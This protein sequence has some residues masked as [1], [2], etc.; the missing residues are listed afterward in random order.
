[1][2][3]AK[4]GHFWLQEAKMV[5]TRMRFWGL[6]RRVQQPVRL[7]V[8]VAYLFEPIQYRCGFL[9]WGWCCSFLFFKCNLRFS[10]TKFIY[11]L[12]QKESWGKKWEQG[13]GSVRNREGWRLRQTVWL[14]WDLQHSASYDS[15]VRGYPHW[16]ISGR[17]SSS[18][19]KKGS[20][21]R[22]LGLESLFQESILPTRDC[23]PVSRQKSYVHKYYYYF[24]SRKG[25]ILLACQNISK[26][27]F[28]IQIH[29]WV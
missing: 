20:C 21:F 2:W 15:Q 4:Y 29:I 7:S 8:K 1:M 12:R 19:Q 9:P 6:K 3:P 24:L 23:K 13:R 18:S 16:W 22:S 25:G 14:Q 26:C 5:M 10:L 28:F 11:Y 17:A 27:S